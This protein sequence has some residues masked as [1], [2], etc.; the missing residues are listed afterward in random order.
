MPYVMSWERFAEERGEARG[1]KLGLEI[2]EKRGEERGEKRGEKRGEA[3]ALLTVFRAKFGTPEPEVE[4][5]IYEAPSQ[6]LQRWLQRILT[7]ERPE[8][9]FK[10]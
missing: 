2:G 6:Q 10:G 4:K 9:L 7:A 5:R 3:K 1:K 8:D